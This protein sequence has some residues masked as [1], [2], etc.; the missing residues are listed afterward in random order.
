M[1]L[2]DLT[3]TPTIYRNLSAG[4]P[5]PTACG[6]FLSY[7]IGDNTE[8][9][10]IISAALSGRT[11]SKT[12]KNSHRKHVSYTTLPQQA[13]HAFLRVFFFFFKFSG[14]E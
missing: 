11:H 8:D 7:E 12:I 10:G 3:I 4:I 9:Q 6:L 13:T 1:L 14:K 5:N 2:R